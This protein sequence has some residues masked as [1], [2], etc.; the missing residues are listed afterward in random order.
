MKEDP[1]AL[2]S[3]SETQLE[4]QILKI[5]KKV[6]G[7]RHMAKSNDEVKVFVKSLNPKTTESQLDSAFKTFGHVVS[8]NLL[9]FPDGTPKNCG[10]VEFQD[11]HAAQAAIRKNGE[12]TVCGKLIIVEPVKRR[13]INPHPTVYLTALV[14]SGCTPNHI[15]PQSEILKDISTSEPFTLSIADGSSMISSGIKGNLTAANLEVKDIEVVPG[16]SNTLLSVYAFLKDKKDIWFKWEDMSVNVGHLDPSGR[17]EILAKGNANKGLFEV[18]LQQESS[19]LIAAS[20][21]KTWDLW[22]KRFM[23]HGFTT[24]KHTKDSGAVR[25]LDII[26]NIPPSLSCNGCI[27]GKMHRLPH[28]PSRYST[29]NLKGMKLSRIAIDILHMPLPSLNG[30]KYAIGITVVSANGFK[31]CYPC[32]LQSEMVTKLKFMKSYLENLTGEKISEIVVD[33][34]GENLALEVKE[35]CLEAGIILSKTGTE[36]H[37]S[38]GQIENW[39]RVTLDCWRSHQIT[40]GCNPNLWADGLCYLAYIH[41]RL[42]HAGHSITPYEALTGQAPSVHDLR[43]FGCLVLPMSCQRTDQGQAFS[44]VNTWNICWVRIL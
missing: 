1:S 7:P 11:K 8:V 4:A 40:I 13:E 10:F 33:Q 25:G 27:Q 3:I 16:L 14:D 9:Y 31:I 44:Q 5:V 43:V 37:Q 24:L 38:N 23:H 42:V 32:K 29:E 17:H 41:N 26:G 20:M 6:T 21:E 34:G 12:I 18:D 15:T 19:A 30:A 39:W 2:I 28:P 22:H 35:I 36:E